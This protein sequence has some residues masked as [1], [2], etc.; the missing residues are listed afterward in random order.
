MKKKRWRKIGKGA[1][2]VFMFFVRRPEFLF[3]VGNKFKFKEARDLAETVIEY[4]DKVS[5]R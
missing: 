5:G 3:I 2:R 1:V 4:S